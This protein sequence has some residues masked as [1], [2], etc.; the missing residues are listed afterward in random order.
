MPEAQKLP[1]V[2]RLICCCCGGGTRGRQWHNRDTG[3]GL[4]VECADSIA[5]TETPEEMRAR[6]GVRGVNYCVE[7]SN[8]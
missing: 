4:C 3:Y 7:E 5:L 8:G 1:A 2:R 6:Y